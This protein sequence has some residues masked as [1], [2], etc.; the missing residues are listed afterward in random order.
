MTEIIFKTC[1][2]ASPRIRT[3]LAANLKRFRAARG[4]TQEQLAARCGLQKTYV[5]DVE[6]AAVNVTLASLETLAKGLNCR[7]ADLFE[8]IDG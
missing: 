3:R 8:E 6:Q 2:M 7:V 1:R 5:S 4:Y